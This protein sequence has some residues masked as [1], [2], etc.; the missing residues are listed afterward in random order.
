MRYTSNTGAIG[1]AFYDEGTLYTK[2]Y[3]GYLGY[4]FIKR[5]KAIPVENVRGHDAS[6]IAFPE[7]KGLFISKERWIGVGGYDENLVFGGD[8][9]DLGIKLWIMGY[10]NY[11]YS[12]SIQTHFRVF[13]RE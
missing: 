5:V 12:K 6:E 7:G 4:Y 2:G 13:E 9:N 11:L 3:G 8:D 1:L 10:K